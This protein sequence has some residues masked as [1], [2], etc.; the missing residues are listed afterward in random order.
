MADAAEERVPGADALF[1][2]A[3][4]MSRFARLRDSTEIHAA[5]SGTLSPAAQNV[6]GFCRNAAMPRSSQRPLAREQDDADIPPSSQDSSLPRLRSGLLALVR[7]VRQDDLTLRQLAVLSL[8]VWTQGPHTIRGLAATMGVYKTAITRAVDRLGL[9]DLAQRLP[10]PADSR[11]V[12]IQATPR[13]RR[14]AERLG[15]AFAS[16]RP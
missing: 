6:P 15:A 4:K 1:V 8:I 16:Q 5:I 11:S 12:L 7:D 9:Y 3:A 10:D 2:V 13:G 14:L